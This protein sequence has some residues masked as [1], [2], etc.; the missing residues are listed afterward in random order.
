[1]AFDP[2]IFKSIFKKIYLSVISFTTLNCLLFWASLGLGKVS[3][4]S[5][6]AILKLDEERNIWIRAQRKTVLVLIMYKNECSAELSTCHGR[7]T[8]L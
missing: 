7:Q 8:V 5:F 6:K 3:I 4:E 1:M 2:C